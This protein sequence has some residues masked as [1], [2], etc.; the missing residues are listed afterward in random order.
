MLFLRY[1]LLLVTVAYFALLSFNLWKAP[2]APWFVYVMVGSLIL[3]FV[4]LLMDHQRTG[5]RWRVF[6]IVSLWFDAKEAELSARANRSRPDE[7]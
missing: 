7:Q 1:F 4:Y 5:E 6:R 2:G 3:N